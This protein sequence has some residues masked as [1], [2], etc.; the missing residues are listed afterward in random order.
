MTVSFFGAASP[1]EVK[2]LISAG[3]VLFVITLL[4]N[5]LAAWIVA[6]AQ[7]WRQ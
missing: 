1:E 5:W 6:K 3:L 2:A 4:I 7:P